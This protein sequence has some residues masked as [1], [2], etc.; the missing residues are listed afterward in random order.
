MNKSQKIQ[1]LSSLWGQCLCDHHKDRDTK[2]L[3]TIRYCFGD[4][5]YIVEHFGYIVKEYIMNF[6]TLN[7]AQDYLIKKLCE[8]IKE[9]CDHQLY[10][11]ERSDE[12]DTNNDSDYW[13]KILSE[14]E[15][16]KNLPVEDI[17]PKINEEQYYEME[18]KYNQLRYDYDSADKILNANEIPKADIECPEMLYSLN[19]RL[20]LLIKKLKNDQKA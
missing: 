19:F 10:A 12:Y 17:E 1:G 4:I 20:K 9:E 3:I 14:L 11:L 6:H 2:H 13:N 15:I 18:R 7:V 8:Q 5:Q 16:T